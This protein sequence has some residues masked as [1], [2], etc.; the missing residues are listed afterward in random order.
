MGYDLSYTSAAQNSLSTVIAL[1]PIV[2]LLVSLGFFKMPAYKACGAG[3]L[4]SLVIAAAV[5]K[6]PYMLV[7]Q[8]ALE[9]GSLALI[10]IIW[11]IVSAFFTYN[12]SLNTGAMDRI[13]NLMSNLSGDRRIQALAIAWGFGGFLESAAGFGTAVAIPAS[14][15]IALKFDAFSA[16]IICL[17]ANTV[18]VAFGVIG[19]P[20]TTLATI[21]ELPITALSLDVVVQLTPFVLLVP[22]LIVFSVTKSFAGFKGVLLTTL[23]AGLSFGVSQFLVAKYIGPE[24]PAIVG[25]VVSFAAI[26]ASAKISPPKQEWRFPHESQQKTKNVDTTGNFKSQLIAWAP[27]ILLLVLVLGTS[28]L[29]PAIHQ[30]ASQAQSVVYIYNGPG[31]KPLYIDWILTPGTLI[32]VSAIL[33]GLIQGM[34]LRDLTKTFRNTLFQLQKTILTVITIVSMAKILG[35]SG[36]VGAIAAALAGSTGAF[37]PIFA[38]LIGALGTFITGSDTSANVL[39]GLLQKQ[40]ALQIGANPSWIAAANTS[41]ACVGKLISPQSIAIATTATNLIGKEGE[42]LN[43]TLRYVG[44]FVIALGFITYIFAF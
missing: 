3:L 26:I 16:A 13:K 37:Y 23:I 33:G 40:T 35:Y 9:G 30:A 39:F 38:P 11:V 1:I 17:I 21:T 32:M 42:I 36:M 25:S 12:I 27:Y 43:L 20:V 6:M 19:I 28:K 22:F 15:L 2:W 29:V 10:P 44:G 31:G 18:A 41:G 7:L 34:S 14:L 5:W 4:L 8:A 24:L